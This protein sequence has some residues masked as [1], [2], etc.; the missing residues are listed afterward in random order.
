MAREPKDGMKINFYLDKQLVS[1]LKDFCTRT[2]RTMTKVVEI[3]L[4]EYLDKHKE[5]KA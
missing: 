4:S 2:G 5:D 1:R 3:A